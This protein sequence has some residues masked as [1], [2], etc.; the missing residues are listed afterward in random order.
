MFEAK[1][2][3]AIVAANFDQFFLLA[4][5]HRTPIRVDSFLDGRI[6]FAVSVDVSRDRDVRNGSSGSRNGLV[7]QRTN[8]NLN[9]KGSNIKICLVEKMI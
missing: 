9:E 1:V 7:A 8:R 5:L 6:R 3:S 4:R 2:L